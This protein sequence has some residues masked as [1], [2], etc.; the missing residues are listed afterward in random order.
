MRKKYGYFD[1]LVS[2]MLGVDV[3]GIVGTRTGSKAKCS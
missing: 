1:V 3:D 2:T